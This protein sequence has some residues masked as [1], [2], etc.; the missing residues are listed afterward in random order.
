MGNGVLGS[1]ERILRLTGLMVGHRG[2]FGF[3]HSLLNGLSITVVFP[4]VIDIYIILVSESE[5]S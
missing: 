4:H 2:S 3:I 5:R 1:G